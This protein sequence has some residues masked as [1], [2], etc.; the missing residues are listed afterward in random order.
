MTTKEKAKNLVDTFFMLTH[1]RY[2][3]EIAK[4]CALKTVDEILTTIVKFPH[5]TPY[6]FGLT[7]N[8][9]NF[10]TENQAVEYYIE[11]KQEIENL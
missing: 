5:C 3:I 11:V 10:F 9:E 6:H 7:S 2:D 8:G 1:P 4:K